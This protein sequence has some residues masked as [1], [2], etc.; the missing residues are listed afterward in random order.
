MSFEEEEFFI[1][2]FQLEMP[3]API[4]KGFFSKE[5]IMTMYTNRRC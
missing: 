5:K 1:N 3:I 4:D 2:A